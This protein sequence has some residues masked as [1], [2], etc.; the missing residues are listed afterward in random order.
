MSLSDLSLFFTLEFLVAVTEELRVEP[1]LELEPDLVFSG[2]LIISK[3]ELKLT[4]IS[5]K[6]LRIVL[7]FLL[8]YR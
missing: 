1:E 4:E 2:V 8:I 7:V 3:S 5:I 6:A